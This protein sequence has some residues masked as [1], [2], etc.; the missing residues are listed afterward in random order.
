VRCANRQ[1]LRALAETLAQDVYAG[2]VVVPP[3][4]FLAT[5]CWHLGKCADP[6]LSELPDSL[7][8]LEPFVPGKYYWLGSHAVV[9][10]AKAAILHDRYFQGEIYEDRAVGAVL[11][12]YGFAA[13]ALDLVADGVLASATHHSRP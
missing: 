5:R 6:H 9:A 3:A 1:K 4:P 2:A 12:H 11:Q 13:T 8:Q 7:L 10:L